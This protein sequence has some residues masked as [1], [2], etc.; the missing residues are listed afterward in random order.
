MRR[1]LVWTLTLLALNASGC[2]VAG[3]D[4]VNEEDRYVTDCIATSECL[5]GA[6]TDEEFAACILEREPEVLAPVAAFD[7]DACADLECFDECESSVSSCEACV[8]ERCPDTWDACHGD[9][10]EDYE[11]KDDGAHS[12]CYSIR[13]CFGDCLDVDDA[14]SCYEA[15]Y[16]DSWVDARRDYYEMWARSSIDCAPSCFDADSDAETCDSCMESSFGDE[17]P[18]CFEH[19]GSS[20]NP[21]GIYS[22]CEGIEDPLMLCLCSTSDPSLCYGL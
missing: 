5:E 7:L 15:C 6:A 10:W 20:G 2:G 12:S 11:A 17:V 8:E 9:G 13:L 4:A 22:E 3:G 14:A 21:S 18:G 16:F 19:R 1:K